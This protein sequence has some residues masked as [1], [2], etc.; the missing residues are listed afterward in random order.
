MWDQ[1]YAVN[2]PFRQAVSGSL[3]IGFLGV[4][5][6]HAISREYVVAVVLVC[7]ALA[8]PTALFVSAHTDERARQRILPS[9]ATQPGLLS[10]LAFV[11]GICE[12]GGFGLKQ[13]VGRGQRAIG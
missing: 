5:I 13:D 8:F 3:S 2:D 1:A 9:V 10:A 6:R 4:G 12:V 7:V 11:L